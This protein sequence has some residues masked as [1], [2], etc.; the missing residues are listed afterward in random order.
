[1]LLGLPAPFVVLE[2]AHEIAGEQAA[3]RL[4]IMRIGEIRPHRL[5]ALI[6]GERLVEALQVLQRDAA[7]G[8]RLGII[9]PQLKRPV[10]ALRAHRQSA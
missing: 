9:R 1:M 10:V 2:A 7:I 6:M 3:Q 4:V 8:E 5:R